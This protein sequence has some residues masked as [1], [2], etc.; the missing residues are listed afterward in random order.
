[1]NWGE[2]FLLREVREEIE[3]ER[4]HLWRLDYAQRHNLAITK[5]SD[6]I[7]PTD[8]LTLPLDKKMLKIIIPSKIT[9]S[10]IK[11]VLKRDG[12]YKGKIGM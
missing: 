1:M 12:E 4:L 10:E 8:I 5:R 2:F 7:K 6:I 9:L 11:E 3:W